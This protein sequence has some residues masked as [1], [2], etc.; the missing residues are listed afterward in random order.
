M[1]GLHERFVAFKN[2]AG[3]FG[4]WFGDIIRPGEKDHGSG[5]VW[6]N[7]PLGVLDCI[8]HPGSAESTVEDRQG[9]HILFEGIPECDA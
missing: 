5:G 9:S 3:G 8:V 2:F 7:G 1:D 6:D 4:M